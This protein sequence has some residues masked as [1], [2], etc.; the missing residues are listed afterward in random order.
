MA[1]VS[2]CISRGGLYDGVS[3]FEDAFP[4]CILHHTQ[5]DTVL[6]TATSAKELTLGHCRHI[7]T[8]LNDCFTYHESHKAGET[9]S[10]VHVY[11]PLSFSVFVFQGFQVFEVSHL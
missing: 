1:C 10:Q 11:T 4:F 3:R 2:T 7:Q 9:T 8:K 6:H 5:T